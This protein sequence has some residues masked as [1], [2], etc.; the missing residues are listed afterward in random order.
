MTNI[1]ANFRLGTKMMASFALILLLMVVVGTVALERLNSINNTVTLMT[2]HLSVEQRDAADILQKTEQMRFHALHFITDG[3]IDDFQLYQNEYITLK[4]MLAKMKREDI[5]NSTNVAAMEQ[6]IANADMYNKNLERIKILLAAHSEG[7]SS[8]VGK[9]SAIVDENMVQLRDNVSQL[10]DVAL[11]NS[12]GN[13]FLHWQEMVRF[14]FQLMGSSRDADIETVKTHYDMATRQLAK[15]TTELTDDVDMVLLQKIQ[16]AINTYWVG[17]QN[18]NDNIAEKQALISSFRK[19]KRVYDIFEPSR[20]D[21]TGGW[22][23]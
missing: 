4:D 20:I 1:F 14:T 8:V 9:Q 2:E 3:N 18:L 13:V 10:N 21:S 16:A 22:L 5:D 6:L 12:V 23:E 11:L 7:F 15:L 17:V 19:G